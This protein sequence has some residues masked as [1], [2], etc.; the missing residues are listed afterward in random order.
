MMAFG[1]VVVVMLGAT[2]APT[3]IDSGFV[4]IT[5]FVSVAWAVN[6]FAPAVV[7]TP[8]MTPAAL[9]RVRPAGSVPALIDQVYGA[10]PPVAA[11]T[12]A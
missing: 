2:A 1:N 4:M 9:N 10:V 12:V 6:G 7:G 11:S 3:R 8:E 5:P